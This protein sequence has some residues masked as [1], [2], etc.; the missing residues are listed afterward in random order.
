MFK[1]FGNYNTVYSDLIGV[2]KINNPIE[3]IKE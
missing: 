1:Q 3:I 2:N